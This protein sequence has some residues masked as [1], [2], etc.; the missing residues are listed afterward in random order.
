MT[1]ALTGSISQ[2]SDFKA[3][4]LQVLYH[5]SCQEPDSEAQLNSAGVCNAS[6]VVAVWSG[7]EVG[8]AIARTVPLRHDELRR[9]E[10]QIVARRHPNSHAGLTSLNLLLT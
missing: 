3:L 10:W 1:S 5:D 7:F 4:Q 2:V 6:S 8:Q 9:V